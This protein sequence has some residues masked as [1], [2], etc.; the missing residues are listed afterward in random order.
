VEVPA[1]NLVH[2]TPKGCSRLDASRHIGQ[3]YVMPFQRAHDR[4]D[5]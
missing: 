4:T 2:A 5:I 3:P 1:G